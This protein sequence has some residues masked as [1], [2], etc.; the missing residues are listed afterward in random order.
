[1]YEV[2]HRPHAECVAGVLVLVL[3]NVSLQGYLAHRNPPPV[4]P[5]CSAMPGDLW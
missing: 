5:H 4:G 3:I 2:P 1:M